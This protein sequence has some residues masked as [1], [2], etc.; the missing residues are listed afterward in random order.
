MDE[1][2]NFLQHTQ[3]IWPKLPSRNRSMSPSSP[4]GWDLWF[5]MWTILSIP[6][7]FFNVFYMSESWFLARNIWIYLGCILNPVLRKIHL[8]G[9]AFQT[10]DKKL[11]HLQHQQW[12]F[13]I[14][15]CTDQPFIIWFHFSYVDTVRYPCL[16]IHQNWSWPRVEGPAWLWPV[17]VGHG[18]QDKGYNKKPQKTCESYV[19]TRPKCEK[20]THI[21]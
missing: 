2:C 1:N 8:L 11:S 9:F 15:Y 18:T 21:I 3:V 17:G 6:K 10:P 19:G 7:A 14:V 4:E 13:N 16:E 12:L 5:S 20:H